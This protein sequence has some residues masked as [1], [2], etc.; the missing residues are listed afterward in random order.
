MRSLFSSLLLL[1]MLAI[2]FPLAVQ[3]K[4]PQEKELIQSLQKAEA[5]I[6]A[7]AV[8]YSE[9]IF[10][11]RKRTAYKKQ[12]IQ[13]E[14]IADVNGRV[15]GEMQ[16]DIFDMT[17]G[18]TDTKRRE[19]ASGCFDGTTQY[20][21]WGKE[22]F[23]NNRSYDFPWGLNPERFATYYV[24]VP[25]SKML[26][27]KGIELIREVSRGDKTLLLVETKSELMK[28]NKEKRYR[29][30]IDPAYNFAVVKKSQIFQL[31]PGNQWIEISFYQGFNYKEVKPH[32][33]LPFYVLS[34]NHDVTQEVLKGEEKAPVS[35]RR[36]IKIKSWEVNPKIDDATFTFKFPPGIPV[37]DHRKKPVP[38]SDLAE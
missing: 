12:N 8:E 7:L 24:G 17:P 20:V 13:V 30:I 4:P 2:F 19:V 31:L 25:V 29:F 18:Y 38:L 26:S 3:A 14:I 16:N 27:D 5:L 35:R 11:Y 10:D 9:E 15:K 34:E 32:V 28:G 33:W 6:T 23:I 22:G 36:K 37:E 1:L 21:V